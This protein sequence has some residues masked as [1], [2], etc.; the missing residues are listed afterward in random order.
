MGGEGAVSPAAKSGVQALA[1]IVLALV[2]VG[3]GVWTWDNWDL[4]FP[5]SFTRGKG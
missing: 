1:A 5:K 3:V 2:I 4:L